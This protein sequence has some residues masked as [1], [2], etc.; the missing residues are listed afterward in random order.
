MIKTSTSSESLW[1]LTIAPSIWALHFL[2]SY[3]TAAVWCAKYAGVGGSL[4]GVR[5]AIAVY[6]VMALIGIAVTGWIGYRRHTFGIGTLPHD[7]DSPED[8]HRF[9][10][11]ATLLLAGLSAVA[12]LFVASVAVFIGNCD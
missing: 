1:M 11:F 2:V 4:G 10:G 12:T 3:V 5:I 7:A 9:M 6:T 8:R